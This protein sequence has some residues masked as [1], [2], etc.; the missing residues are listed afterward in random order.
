MAKIL[1]IGQA[2]PAVSQ[3]VPYDT[4]ML[5]EWL[6]EIG[7]SKEQAQEIFDFDAVYNKFLG[8]N[9]RG[10]IKPTLK[11]MNEYFH[12][13][14]HDKICEADKIWLLG[15]VA[16]DFVDSKVA[17]ENKKWI[18]TIHPSRMNYN[19]FQ[20]TKDSVLNK[21]KEFLQN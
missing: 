20:K 4:T 17:L 9:E 13:E 21:I 11:Q 2:P 7:I 12:A 8:R 6:S 14:L 19:L 5:Y 3:K 16:F 1:I 18:K 10:H 15:N